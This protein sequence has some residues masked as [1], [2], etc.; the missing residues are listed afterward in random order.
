MGAGTGVALVIPAWNEAEAIGAVLDEVPPGTV[1][2]V[3]VV[4]GSES[5]PTGAVARRHGARVLVQQ[6]RGYGAACWTGA[7]AALAENARVVAFLDGDYADPPADLPRLLSPIEEGRAE[8]V[9]GCRDL[10]RFPDAL[11]AHAR[12]GNRL[13]LLVLRAFLGAQPFSDLPSFKVIRS[14]AL[15]ALRMREMTYGWT[16]EMLTKAARAGLRIEEVRVDYRPRLG[17]R[18]K[19]AGSLGGSVAAAVKLLGCAVTYASSPC[20]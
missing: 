4:V 6:A 16:I 5:D 9:L 18:S 1:D 2:Q 14:D 17:G 20:E 19:V 8:L 10:T 11:P 15:R 12:L 13:V 7:R 3:L